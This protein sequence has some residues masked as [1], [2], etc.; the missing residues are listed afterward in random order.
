MEEL[1][2]MRQART[3]EVTEVP[4]VQIAGGERRN[5]QHKLAPHTTK[6]EEKMLRKPW[7]REWGWYERKGDP[8]WARKAGGESC[9]RKGGKRPEE[10]VSGLAQ[11]KDAKV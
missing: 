3:G 8:I 7:V 10:G 9:Q 11:C 4:N 5:S 1:N 2:P 6:K